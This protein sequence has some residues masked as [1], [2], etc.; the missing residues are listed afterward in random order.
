MLQRLK[1]GKNI[2]SCIPEN[3]GDEYMKMDSYYDPEEIKLVIKNLC[4]KTQLGTI[5]WD[6]VDYKPASLILGYEYEDD[7]DTKNYISDL[8]EFVFEP[9]GYRYELGISGS[10]KVDKVCAGYVN[11]KLDVYQQDGVYLYGEEAIIDEAVASR[12]KDETDTSFQEDEFGFLSLCDSIFQRA[13]EW[14]KD[15]FF[16]YM[17]NRYFYPM[18]GITKQHREH[19]LCRLM[20]KLMNER[21]VGDFHKMIMDRPYREQLLIEL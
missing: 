1:I 5:T 17:D 15:D 12:D 3:D 14:L 20:V 18:K 4:A 7:G 10:I 19:P 11:P 2:R 13:N 9:P 6:C 21:R 8:A 16:L